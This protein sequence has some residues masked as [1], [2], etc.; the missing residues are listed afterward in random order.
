MEEEYREFEAKTV[1]EAII[2]AMKAF[3]ADFEDLDIKVLSEGSKG[4]FGLVGT[5]TAKIQAR[6]RLCAAA[7]KTPPAQAEKT[8]D[9]KAVRGPAPAVP[10]ERSRPPAGAADET[11]AGSVP[12]EEA[13]AQA[14]D[15]T[16]TIL[17]LMGMP[18]E[19][20]V[21]EEGLLE[22]V[23][24]GSGII[25]GKRGQT[26][27]ALQFVIN[28]IVN[29]SRTE[30]VYITL[31]TEGYRQRHVN[32]LRTMALKMGQKARRTGQAVS[33]EKMNPYDRRIIHLALKNENG[34]NTKSIGE[35]VYKKVVIV[36]RK[37]SR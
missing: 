4:L 21:R 26:L 24:D 28:R 6:H 27:D 12:P 16:G 3:H 19:I 22:I 13:L 37:S 15:M 31:D 20:K 10:K 7:M 30:P 11:S 2:L 18:A 17:G 5:R 35:G 8:P 9:P 29:K 25:I 36:P 34:L 23:G 14:R 33:L 1:D 32:H